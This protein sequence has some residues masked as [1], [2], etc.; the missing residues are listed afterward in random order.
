MFL[1]CALR[2]LWD[3]FRQFVLGHPDAQIGNMEEQGA[4]SDER[5]R[6]VMLANSSQ[7]QKGVRT[8]SAV[9]VVTFRTSNYTALLLPQ[10]T[11]K[12]TAGAD[13]LMLHQVCCAS[14][15]NGSWEL[16]NPESET[17]V[18]KGKV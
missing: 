9:P 7:L 12:P 4:K 10:N 8:E 13:E 5:A 1:K 16:E 18:E 6:E 11:R 15:L 17:H 2:R 3:V 14:P